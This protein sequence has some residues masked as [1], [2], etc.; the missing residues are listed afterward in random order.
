MVG[1]IGFM[2]TGFLRRTDSSTCVFLGGGIFNDIK[3][4]KVEQ[5]TWISGERSRFQSENTEGFFYPTFTPTIL[6]LVPSGQ[7]LKH[8]TF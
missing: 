2:E 8:D 4:G 7:P 5:S 3:G 1:A 6:I